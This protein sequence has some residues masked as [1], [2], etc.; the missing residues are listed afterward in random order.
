VRNRST[1]G[2]SIRHKRK[3]AIRN[4]TKSPTRIRRMGR[5]NSSDPVLF[6]ATV[7]SFHIPVLRRPVVGQLKPINAQFLI[8]LQRTF[9][10]A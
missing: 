3:I 7:A 6:F 2:L 9:P 8:K 5:P 1:L 4:K 10:R